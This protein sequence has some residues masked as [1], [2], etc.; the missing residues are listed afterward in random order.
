VADLRDFSAER[1]KTWIYEVPLSTVHHLREKLNDIPPRR[2]FPEELLAQ[3]DAPVLA[4]TVKLWMLELN[5]PLGTWEGWNE[6][7]RVYQSG[8][9]CIVLSPIS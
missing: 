6:F 2:P 4:G 7:R 8:K 1:R 5:P 3:Y 9:Y